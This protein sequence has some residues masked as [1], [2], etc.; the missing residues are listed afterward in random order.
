MIYFSGISLKHLERW[1]LPDD[2]PR[3]CAPEESYRMFLG[4]HLNMIR[5]GEKQGE[6]DPNYARYLECVKHCESRLKLSFLEFRNVVAN[7]V[8]L[9]QQFFA[10]PTGGRGGKLLDIIGKYE[11]L[12]Y[13]YANKFPAKSAAQ[14]N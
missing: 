5:S 13:L 7:L 4:M 6:Y 8:E 2:R 1:E 11:R 10:D 3:F 9:Y 14:H 12:I